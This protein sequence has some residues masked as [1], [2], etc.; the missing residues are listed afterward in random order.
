MDAA[1]RTLSRRRLA[2]PGEPHAWGLRAIHWALGVSLAAHAAALSVQFVAPERWLRWLQSQ[3]L[4]VVVVN[5][6]EES[7][8]VNPQA[9]AQVQLAGG[10]PADEKLATADQLAAPIRQAGNADQEERERALALREEQQQLLADVRRTLATLPPPDPAR[11][12][13]D[14]QVRATE[15]RRQQLLDRLAAIEKRI[16][17][18][19]L[20]PRRRYISPATKE[21]IYALYYEALRRRVEERGTREFPEV[22][23]RKLFGELVM[24]LTVDARGRVKSAEILQSSGDAELDRQAL[25]IVRRASPFGP[26]SAEMLKQVDEVIVTSRFRFT[27]DDGLSTQLTDSSAR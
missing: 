17:E 18:Q 12:A 21:S 8:A 13:T 25:A 19:N 6:V 27:A 14:P 15:E 11:A 7:E 9:L 23:G 20:Q 22:R 5:A 3:P 26:F 16:N 10:G 4:E 1:A 24:N 2:G